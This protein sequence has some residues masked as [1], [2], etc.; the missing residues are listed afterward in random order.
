MRG[1]CERRACSPQWPCGGSLAA[2][3]KHRDVS[4][5]TYYRHRSRA[6]DAEVQKINKRM[7]ERDEGVEVSCTAPKSVKRKRTTSQEIIEETYDTGDESTTKSQ[8]DEVKGK[9]LSNMRAF[10][11]A[12]FAILPTKLSK[13]EGHKLTFYVIHR[14]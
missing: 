10:E 5:A 3:G 13:V 4:T 8:F 14:V 11:S 12:Q 7:L 2:G 1:R 6:M 9:L